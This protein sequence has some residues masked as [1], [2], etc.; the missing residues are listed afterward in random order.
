MGNDGTVK[1]GGVNSRQRLLRRTLVAAKVLHVDGKAFKELERLAGWRAAA[2]NPRAD[3]K[4]LVRAVRY[5]AKD[6]VA[7]N[8]REVAFV[9]H[10]GRASPDECLEFLR[11]CD[12]G[13]EHARAR[14]AE[15]TR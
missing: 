1:G 6:P 2:D 4:D 14:F 9:M 8:E 7:R 12:L 5:T 10:G 15:V 3:A 11:Q 13:G